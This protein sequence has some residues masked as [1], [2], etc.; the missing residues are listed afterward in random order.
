M[1]NFFISVGLLVGSVFASFMLAR[2][3]GGLYDRFFPELIDSI[4]TI[5]DKQVESTVG[6][7]LGYS[8]FIPLL[9]ITLVPRYK[10]TLAIIFVTPAILLWGWGDPVHSY[11]P[12]VF[13]VIAWLLGLALRRLVYRPKI[14]EMKIVSQQ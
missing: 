12:I 2:W 3:L 11:L 7:L 10:K 6:F 13:A 14:V 5:A 1:K 8:F 9:F 4:I